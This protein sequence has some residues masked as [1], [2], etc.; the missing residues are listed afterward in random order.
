[1]CGY[2]TGGAGGGQVPGSEAGEGRVCSIITSSAG[3]DGA[4]RWQT[5][6]TVG[7]GQSGKVFNNFSSCV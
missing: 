5:A 3:T 1:M 2:L 6:R 4:Q 7:A